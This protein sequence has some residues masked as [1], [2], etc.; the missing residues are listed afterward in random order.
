MSHF[1]PWGFAALGVAGITGA[2][3]AKA[4]EGN[5]GGCKLCGCE[6]CNWDVGSFG[7]KLICIGLNNSCSFKRCCCG[8]H[9]TQHHHR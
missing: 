4:D 7:G 2:A 9:F 1:T 5:W 3:L 8:H 6:K